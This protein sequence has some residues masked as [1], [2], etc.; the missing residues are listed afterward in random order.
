VFIA[1]GAARS[2]AGAAAEGGFEEWA[3]GGDGGADYGD[4][5]LDLGPE[6]DLGVASVSLLVVNYFIWG[7]GDAY[8]N[9]VEGWIGAVEVFVYEVDAKA[10]CEHCYA[11]DQENT[12]DGDCGKLAIVSR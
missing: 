5:E 6:K 1:Q 4:V 10:R 11:A 2:W 7:I 9:G 3:E 8:L 12:D